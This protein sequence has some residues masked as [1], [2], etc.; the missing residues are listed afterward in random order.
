MFGNIKSRF[1]PAEEPIAENKWDAIKVT[2]QQPNST[3]A[4]AM[5]RAV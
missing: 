1:Q 4:P 5:K 2:M 3:A